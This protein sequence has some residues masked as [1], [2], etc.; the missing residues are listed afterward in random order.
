MDGHD[1]RK[2]NAPCVQ[3]RMAKFMEPCLLLL[4]RG[5]RSHGY[6]LME[7]L[8]DLGFEGTS[9]DMATL[10]RTLRQLEDDG[11]VLSEWEEGSQGPKKRVYELTE[12]GLILLENWALVIKENR[13]RLARFLVKYEQ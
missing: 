8:G 3:G 9:S 7:R 4:L 5:Q 12:D 1:A 11:M 6:E 10:Y 2:P 13:D